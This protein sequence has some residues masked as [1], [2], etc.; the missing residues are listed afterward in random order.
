[1]REFS[2]W[3]E[4]KY[5]SRVK[6]GTV[7]F[8]FVVAKTRRPG[9]GLRRWETLFTSWLYR[10]ARIDV[11][12]GSEENVPKWLLYPS[13]LTGLAPS[14]TTSCFAA[15]DIRNLRMASIFFRLGQQELLLE[16]AIELGRNFHEFSQD[17]PL[18]MVW[19]ARSF[20]IASI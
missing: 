4:K 17:C 7:R 10:T 12:S 18:H 5:P 6:R 9:I 16:S 14:T 13:F 8:Y 1:M 2:G 19:F 20:T 11:C 3:E 15:P